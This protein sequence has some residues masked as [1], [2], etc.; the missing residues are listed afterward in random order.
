MPEKQLDSHD[1]AHMENGDSSPDGDQPGVDGSNMP[2]YDDVEVKRIMRK[3]DWRLLP[4]LTV[5]YVLSF[6]DRSNIGNAKVAGMNVD[7]GLTGA[8]YNM[9]LTVF[10]FPYAMFEV[11]SNVVLKLMRP[12]WWMT[13]LVVTWGTVLTMQGIVKNYDQLIVTRVLLGLAESGFFPAATYLLTTWYCRWEVQTRLAV[14]FSAASLA[15]AFSGLLA[16]AIQHMDGI[17]GLGGWR[18]I[19]I[20]EGIF[21]VLVGCTIPWVLPDSPTAAG[22]LSQ[23]EK[24]LIISRL[25]HDSGTSSGRVGVEGSFQWR[26]LKDALLDWKIYLGCIIYWGNSI[27]IYGFSFASPTIILEL[28]YSAAQAQ[29]LT[30]PI[31]FVGTCS[32]IFFARLADKR[33]TRWLF[34]I[35]S[36]SISTVGFIGLLAIPHPAL[37]GLTYAFLFCIPARLYPAV[38]GCIS[39]VGNNLA[40][41][42]KRAIGMALLMTIGNLG[43]AVGSNIFLAQQEPHYWLGYGFSLGILICGVISTL[44]LRI[45]TTRINKARDQMPVEEVLAKYSEEELIQMGDKSPLY[46]Y[47][48]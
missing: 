28:G 1:V 18:W 32:T 24:N 34:I 29:L 25:E 43:G 44:V 30:V 9:A 27:C 39:W 48:S 31:Y 3:V 37:P 36:F 42:F 4:P 40:P 45:A 33:Q 13:I 16:F 22:F 19:F 10:F 47:V 26:Y 20:L 6:M 12:S 23:Y 14:F 35:I 2:R 5:L 7:L 8:Q 21:T 41:S 11:P 15:S 46:R 17:A 38:I